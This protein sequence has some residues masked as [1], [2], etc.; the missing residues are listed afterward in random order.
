[1]IQC[2]TLF[3]AEIPES[4]FPD[5]N[6]RAYHVCCPLIRAVYSSVLLNP[7]SAAFTRAD[8]SETADT[9]NMDL[10]SAWVNLHKSAIDLGK[11]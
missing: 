3:R 11:R 2:R 5:L 1:M 6:V 8:M 4:L 7:F 9:G 10:R